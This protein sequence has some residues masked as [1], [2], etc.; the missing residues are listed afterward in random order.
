MFDWG[1]RLKIISRVRTLIPWGKESSTAVIIPIPPR[2]NTDTN[3]TFNSHI[4]SAV[5]FESHID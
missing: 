5:S 1:N 4:A 2:T 3:V